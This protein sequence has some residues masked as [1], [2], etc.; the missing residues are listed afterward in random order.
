MSTNWT[1]NKSKLKV[2]I[3]GFGF[4]GG[5]VSYGFKSDSVEQMIIDPKL[6]HAELEHL[7]PFSNS[8]I[9]DQS[10]PKT[11]IPSLPKGRHPM[12]FLRILWALLP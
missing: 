5:A 9:L 12:L 4:V 3:V 7:G 10:R 1:R 2:G 11:P 8:V 6:G